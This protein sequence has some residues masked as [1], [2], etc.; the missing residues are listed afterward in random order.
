M[1]LFL[2][3][4]ASKLEERD[5]KLTH[6]WF[7][8]NQQLAADLLQP[9]A[10]FLPDLTFHNASYF[11]RQYMQTSSAVRSYSIFL[12]NL[13]PSLLLWKKQICILIHLSMFLC[14]KFP[15]STSS[16]PSNVIYLSLPSVKLRNL[17]FAKRLYFSPFSEKCSHCI[18]EL[19][20]VFVYTS[21]FVG[22]R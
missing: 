22:L 6:W 8:F 14:S 21:C 20:F 10:L 4:K 5:P 15:L 1:A 9:A 16:P 12:A 7:T 18:L 17:S 11:P 19:L 2:L 3:Q 13:Y